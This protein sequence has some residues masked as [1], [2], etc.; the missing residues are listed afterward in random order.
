[1]LEKTEKTTKDGQYRDIGNIGY[2]I[3]KT[4]TKKTTIHKTIDE[5]HQPHKRLQGEPRCS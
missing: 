2:T 4:K 1:M 3:H 5:Q